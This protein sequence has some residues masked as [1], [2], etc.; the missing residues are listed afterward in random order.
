MEEEGR[1]YVYHR[2]PAQMWGT[3]LY[4][5]NILKVKNPGLYS[6]KAE[7]YNGREHVMEQ[8]VP[9]LNTLWNDVL[10]FTAVHPQ[11]LKKSLIEA[12]MKPKE[13]K[14]Y[15]IDPSLFDPKH[16][17]VYL[18]QDH[19]LNKVDPDDFT[20]FDPANLAQ[21]SVIPE[22]TRQYYKES[23]SKGELP[24]MYVGVPHI[25]YKGSIDVA[26]LPTI[27]V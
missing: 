18:Y 21:Y 25:L 6:E 23:F 12:G 20:E 1:R 4:P 19:V 5:L 2:V 11:E 22:K 10:H 9:T 17:T 7:K 13:M 14:F 27:T 3:T 8:I 26:N 15:Q 24:L 16:T